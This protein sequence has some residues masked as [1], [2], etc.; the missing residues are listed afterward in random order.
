LL[1]VPTVEDM[2][3]ALLAA[4]TGAALAMLAAGGAASQA[5]R[6]RAIELI[7]NAG[8]P[9]FRDADLKLALDGGN[10]LR[11]RKLGGDQVPGLRAAVQTFAIQLETHAKEWF[12]GRVVQVGLADG[13][14]SD[15]ERDVVG[16]VAHDL[17]LSQAQAQ[18]VIA[19]TEEAAQAG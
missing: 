4:T 1:A 5:A 3:A 17:G 19:L 9:Q 13:P 6:R 8:A 14:L 18:D 12:L 2:Q 10:D 11:V 16:A 15:A 7:M